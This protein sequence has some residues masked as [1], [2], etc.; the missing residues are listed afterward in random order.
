MLTICSVHCPLPDVV[1]YCS[2]HCLLGACFL[3]RTVCCAHCIVLT[4]QYVHCLLRPTLVCS[5]FVAGHTLF[6]PRFAVTRSP[7]LLVRFGA[8]WYVQV[9]FWPRPFVS[10]VRCARTPMSCV[11]TLLQGRTL[12]LFLFFVS[13]FVLFCCVFAFSDMRERKQRK[14]RQIR[15]KTSSLD[16]CS[17][18]FPAI[19][20]LGNLE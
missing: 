13:C 11:E 1:T 7:V 18:C 15:H 16:V 6:C 9:L 20:P 19:Q 5:R 12:F 2:V 4:V 14:F 17:L 10:K 8:V 3:T